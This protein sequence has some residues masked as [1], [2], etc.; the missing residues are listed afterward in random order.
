MKQLP[1][2][3]RTSIYNTM[4]TMENV[5]LIR[6]LTTEGNELRYDAD[7]RNHGHFKCE[8]CGEV[9]DIE[10]DLP[11]PNAAALKGFEISRQDLLIW[12]LC[13]DCVKKA[14]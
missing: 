9:F 14:S 10:I 2:L 5:G 6:K 12:G 8:S 4:T 13:P 1:G 3:S 7:T 11:E